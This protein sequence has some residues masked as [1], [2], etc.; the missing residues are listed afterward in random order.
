MTED[1]KI[2]LVV[3]GGNAV[4]SY[5]AGALKALSGI[6]PKGS[7]KVISASSVGV[8]NAY[9]YATDKIDVL[10][11]CWKNLPTGGLFSMFRALRKDSLLP[12]YID[13]VMKETD[14]LDAPFYVTT[15]EPKK[16]LV[17]YWKIE[18]AYKESWR[19]LFYQ[20]ASF[21]F[22]VP[23]L[24][25]EE[26]RRLDGGLFDNIPVYPLFY[27]KDLD[28]IL[29]LHSDPKYTPPEECFAD[30]KIVFD[31]VV[32]LGLCKVIDHYKF[33]RKRVAKW[34]DEGY[35]LAKEVFLEI[36]SEAESKE[37]LRSKVTAFYQRKLAERKKAHAA[38]S[39]AT[40]CNNIFWNLFGRKE[41]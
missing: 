17:E 25:S 30:G 4:G 36:F 5:H 32:N 18:G 2:G 38:D 40:M 12:K 22:L 23:K 10:E 1:L 14:V 19:D 24:R 6:L 31:Y 8:L 13:D 29:I 27:E 9:A 7:V 33:D 20:A 15:S 21:P 3:S 39:L 28:M 37:A 35:A 16:P 26:K 11:D 34:F 41:L